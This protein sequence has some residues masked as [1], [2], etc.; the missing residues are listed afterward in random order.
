MA[1][2]I[3]EKS[4]LAES[5]FAWAKTDQGW[6]LIRAALAKF[7]ELSQETGGRWGEGLLHWAALGNLGGVLDLVARGA[8]VNQL[9]LERR[10]P[11]DWGVEKAYFMAVE[12]PEEMPA[13]TIRGMLDAAEGCALALLQA[14]ALPQGAAEGKEGGYSLI[15]LALRA[16][17]PALSEELLEKGA[18][19]TPEELWGWWMAGK[20]DRG[21][22]RSAALAGARSAAAAIE[23]KAGVKREDFRSKSGWPLGLI[24]TKMH[25]DGALPLEGLALLHEAGAEVDQTLEDDFGLEDLCAR[26][27]DPAGAQSR[28]EKACFS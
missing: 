21:Q 3:D 18:A 28:I 24:A 9:D 20:W 11:L 12:P 1:L 22:A 19:G 2:L 27:P 25:L 13:A 15:E 23:K 14:G 6:P 7:P 4:K 5:L 10:R 17:L 8:E 16:G 26:T